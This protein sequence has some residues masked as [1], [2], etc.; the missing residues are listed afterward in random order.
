MNFSN[1]LAFPT[2][3]KLAPYGVFGY[4]EIMSSS[5]IRPLTLQGLLSSKSAGQDGSPLPS[6]RLLSHSLPESIH[7]ID[8]PPIC[9]Q[10]MTQTNISTHAYCSSM[11]KRIG[12]LIGMA[13]A[14]FSEKLQD[15]AQLFSEAVMQKTRHML[16]SSFSE[17]FS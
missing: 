2:V 4:I 10:T 12:M 14:Q 8:T 7:R 16:K 13:P 17:K 1:I 15:S 3:T 5:E 6:K 11:S 9:C